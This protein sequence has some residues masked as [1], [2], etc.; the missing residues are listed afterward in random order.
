MQKENEES[1]MIPTFLALAD[2][3]MD[4]VMIKGEKED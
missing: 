2:G 1:K 3:W 4:G